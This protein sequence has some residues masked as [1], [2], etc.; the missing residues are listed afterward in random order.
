MHSEQLA[1]QERSVALYRA[2]DGDWLA[3]CRDSPMQSPASRFPDRNP[4]LGR[5]MT[6]EERKYLDEGG[7][8]QLFPF[9][10]ACLAFKDAFEPLAGIA[11]RF[12]YSHRRCGRARRW[13]SG[14]SSRFA[15][16]GPPTISDRS[17]NDL[18][19][20]TNAGADQRV[21]ADHGLEPSTVAPMPISEPSPTVRSRAG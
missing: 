10:R 19:S 4:V 7:S 2:L 12:R 17:G 18:P 6:A 20:V 3:L 9:A 15:A 16:V 1:D 11:C 5:A 14:V 21:I 8:V 13:P